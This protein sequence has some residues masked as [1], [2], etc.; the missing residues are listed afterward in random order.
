MRPEKMTSAMHAR[1]LD[2]VSD[3]VGEEVS[4]QPIGPDHVYRVDKHSDSGIGDRVPHGA[5]L[6]I[7]QDRSRRRWF[8]VR[9]R[10]YPCPQ[11]TP[12]QQ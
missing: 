10:T 8:R 12:V 3:D 6:W 1:S 11:S 5:E 4:A 9:Y 7:S 2:R